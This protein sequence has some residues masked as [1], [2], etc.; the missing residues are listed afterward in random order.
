VDPLIFA[1]K[2][3]TLI[4]SM[5]LPLLNSHLGDSGIN[6]MYKITATVYIDP[7]I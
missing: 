2:F 1:I 4:P 7:I 6:T 5:F 3:K